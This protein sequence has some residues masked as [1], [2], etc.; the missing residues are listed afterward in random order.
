ME[1][2]VKISIEIIFL[3]DGASIRYAADTK[4]GFF[5]KGRCHEFFNISFFYNLV[6]VFLPYTILSMALKSPRYLNLKYS[7][8]PTPT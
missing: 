4:A 3:W 2:Y 6:H 7:V 1:F 8:L 5:S